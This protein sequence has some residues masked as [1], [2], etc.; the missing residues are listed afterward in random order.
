VKNIRFA[1]K[2]LLMP[3]L[4]GLGIL[5]VGVIVMVSN[6]AT[7]ATIGRIAEGH[8]PALELSRDLLEIMSNIQRGFQD[9]AAAFDPGILAETDEL[10]NT[11]LQH[12]DDGRTNRSL[13][14]EVLEGI[15]IGFS[16][17]YGFARETT[18]R[19]ISGEGSDD[20]V[21][22][23]STM[24]SGYRAVQGDLEAFAKGARDS[25][26]G[27]IEEENARQRTTNRWVGG[28]L[29][30]CIVAIAW[31]SWS[32]ARSVSGPLNEVVDVAGRLAE[33][34]LTQRV[35]VHGSDE[36]GQV[37]AALNQALERVRSAV[38]P[39]AETASSLS[40]SSERWATVSQ[41]LAAGAE[42]TSAQAT[43]VS[44]AAEQVSRNVDAVATGV[45]EMNAS[46]REIAQ[47]A[48][49]AAKVA[50]SAVDVAAT[51]SDSINRLGE[52]SGEI[53]DVVKVITAIAEQTNLLALNAT[54]EAAR[55]GEAGKGFAVV[56]NEV[57]EL[58]KETSGATDEIGLRIDNIQADTAQA[59]EAITQIS[60][61]IN[62]IYDI[63]NTIA[64]AVEEQTATTNEI[65]HGV[66]EAAKGSG[67]IATSISG[68]AQAAEETASGA[69]M[70]QSAAHE[71]ATLATDLRQLVARFHYRGTNDASS[72]DR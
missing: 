33:G 30:A 34:D 63:Q 65:A 20:L 23:L 70:T 38:E 39:I 19:M 53:S 31:L 15:S 68:V 46:V 40:S 6:R 48:N 59:V 25:M 64:S 17:Y 1:H 26:A 41:Q 61:I 55:A 42:E 7:S 16:S 58:A 72:G 62:R 57:K 66:A 13:D 60:D 54:I 18:E 11:F 28:V 4:A 47:S 44:V 27:A 67:E 51:T 22:A 2:I 24:Q 43:S 71:L 45:E 10:R 52:S 21:A 35:A 9:A 29:L 8:V 3:I 32:L 49:E 56:A 12:L 36:V 50:T 14:D 37:A 5:F 69:G